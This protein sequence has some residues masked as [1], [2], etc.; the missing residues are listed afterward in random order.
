MIGAA[1]TA[2]TLAGFTAVAALG[3]SAIG[4]TISANQRSAELRE[5]LAAMEAQLRDH[6]QNGIAHERKG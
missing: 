4:M 5:R 3:L 6:L 1:D 2:L